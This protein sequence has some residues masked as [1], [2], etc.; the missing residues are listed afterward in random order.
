MVNY[1]P[2]NAGDVKDGFNPWDG[3]IRWRREWQPTPI[4]L[5]G[6]SLWTEEPGGLPMVLQSRTQLSDLAAAAL[7]FQESG[8]KGIIILNV[9]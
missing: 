9:C 8:E 5:P 4:F 1:L 6:E 2:A 7:H 3:K